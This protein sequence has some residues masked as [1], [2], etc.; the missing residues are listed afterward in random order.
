MLPRPRVIQSKPNT[1]TKSEEAQRETRG[2]RLL[3]PPA[4]PEA[5]SLR[6]PAAH[7]HPVL[8]R[9][10]LLQETMSRL[11][12]AGRSPLRWAAQGGTWELQAECSRA[13]KFTRR[14]QGSAARWC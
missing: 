5:P 3:H 13:P 14:W 10:G 1:Q 9:P 4:E 7:G 2:G 8:L 6:E 12:R 11:L